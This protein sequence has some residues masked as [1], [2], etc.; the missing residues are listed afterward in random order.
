MNIHEAVES[1]SVQLWKGRSMLDMVAEFA[2]TFCPDNLTNRVI[3]RETMFSDLMLKR[4]AYLIE[5]Q[6]ER[7]RAIVEQNEVE[8]FD[9]VIDQLYFLLGDALAF[10]LPLE[11]GFA[12]VH[13]SNMAKRNPDGTVTR[14]PETQKV[15][16]PEGWTAPDLRGVLE[17]AR[18]R[19]YAFELS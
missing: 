17:R 13:R 8:Y 1:G 7:D 19:G 9:A 2:A 14:H 3:D 12:E 15:L 5:E 4:D 6:Q 10:G 18:A 16:K 11:E